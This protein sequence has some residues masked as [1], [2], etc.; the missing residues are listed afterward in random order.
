MNAAVELAWGWTHVDAS[1]PTAAGERAAMIA[2]S[3]AG[4]GLTL[5]HDGA[6][7]IVIGAGDFAISISHGTRLAVAVVGAVLRIGVDLCE[8]VRGAQVRALAARYFTGAERALVITDRDA[9]SLWA[10]KEAGLKALGVGLLDGGMFDAAA[11]CP[12]QI[13]SLREPAYAS[14][15]LE[16][17]LD[18][19]DGAIVALAYTPPSTTTVAPF[20]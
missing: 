16:L 7:P 12:V 20:M 9:A 5:G 2:L 10:A 19:H 1:G 6:R 14:S 3:R 11:A 4:R 17:R 15:E 18:E 13:A 8:L